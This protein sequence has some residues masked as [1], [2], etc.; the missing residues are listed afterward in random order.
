MNSELTPSQ[1]PNT[2]AYDDFAKA[3]EQ[4][5]YQFEKGQVVRGKI[6]EHNSEGAYIDIGGKSPGFVPSRE[7]SLSQVTDLAEF[8]PLQEEMEFSDY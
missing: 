8:L 6:F 3:L 7:A 2:S 4:H 5:D 1:E